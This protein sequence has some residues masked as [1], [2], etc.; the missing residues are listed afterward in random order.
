MSS[1][2]AMMSV[3]GTH[4]SVPLPTLDLNF[5]GQASS[6]RRVSAAAA[7]TN[8]NELATNIVSCTRSSTATYLGSNGLIQTAAVNTPRVEYDVDGN[9]LGLLVE[10]ARTNYVK[11]SAALNSTPT[12]EPAGNGAT[13]VNA[14]VTTAPDGTTTADRVNVGGSGFIFQIVSGLTANTQ[15]T[16][17]WFVKADSATAFVYAFYNQSSPGWITRVQYDPTTGEDFGNGW[18]RFS[19]NI[20]PPSGC[21]S[22]RVYPL[23]HDIASGTVTGANGSSYIWGVQL[24]KGAATTSYI[25]T[26]S[27]TATRQADNITLATSNFGVDPAH[28]TLAVDF[29]LAGLSST[30]NYPRIFELHAGS[31]NDRNMLVSSDEVASSIKAEFVESGAGTII[32]AASSVTYPFS[33]VHAQRRDGT[34]GSI[35][36]NGVLGSSAA[37]TQGT[38]TPTELDLGQGV[39]HSDQ[40]NGH[41]RRLRY[42][43]SALGDNLLK[44]VS[45]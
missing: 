39:A 11:H 24:E 17:S 33:M 20:T 35:A 2:A 44:K 14:N 8:G 37:I 43:P 34:S 32:T 13:T 36:V 30:S 7:K 12:W 25:P 6:F 23:R 15:Y 1:V 40:I 10:E 26:G 21:T 28:A 16:A 38:T 18:Y 22:I 4:S 45:G 9:V 41:I 27:S 5:D 3:V 42:W 29:T 19:V 31:N